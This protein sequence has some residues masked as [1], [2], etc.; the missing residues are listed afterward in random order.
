MSKIKILGAVMA[1]ALLAGCGQTDIQRAK[2][3]QGS[4]SAFTQA[5]TE[6]YRSIVTFEAEEMYDWPDANYFADKGLQAANGEVVLPEEIDN[7]RQPPDESIWRD[8]Q[9]TDEWVA[10]GDVGEMIDGRARLMT[11]LNNGARDRY[12]ELAARAQGR[13][14]CWLEQQEENHQVAHIVA[15]RDDFWAALEELEG[16]MAPEVPVAQPEPMM[17]DIYIVYFDWDRSDIR[18]DAAAVIADVTN[19][20][21]S[22]GSP[23]ISV[24]GH[25]DL[26]G[27]D[28]YNMG[29]SLRRADSV[30][31]ALISGG[32]SAS[33]ITTAGRGEAEPAVPTADGVREQ[34]NRRAEIIIQQ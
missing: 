34:A 20:A 33:Q 31:N 12:P 3:M 13:F 11:V 10:G 32:I 25:T 21:A 29:L 6:E 30:R 15:C 18:P 17:P 1:V 9:L 8:W 28:D 7:W 27:S 16:L 2:V 19:A 14:D 24:T 5:L 26:S 22:L 4:G 23:P